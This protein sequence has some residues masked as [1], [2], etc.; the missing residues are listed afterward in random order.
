M[1]S[2]Q[3]TLAFPSPEL[4][5]AVNDLWSMI[6]QAAESLNAQIE[7]NK[8][9]KF[10]LDEVTSNS[11]EESE[12]V[13]RLRE[14]ASNL[15][16]E[17]SLREDDV[18]RLKQQIESFGSLQ[19][20][21]NE[22]NHGYSKAQEEIVVLNEQLDLMQVLQKNTD[23][24]ELALKKSVDE[25]LH[26]NNQLIEASEETL[27]LHNE[28]SE[29]KNQIHQISIDGDSNSL[30]Q[31][32]L[33]TE[34]HRVKE[35]NSEL[36]K[37]RFDY[38]VLKSEAQIENGKITKDHEEL[39]FF[40]TSL[41]AKNLV[42]DSALADE[43]SNNE[44]LKSEISKLIDMNSELTNLLEDSKG[45]LALNENLPIQLSDVEQELTETKNNLLI[46]NK[47]LNDLRRKEIEFNNKIEYLEKEIESKEKAFLGDKS[48]N[49]QV[50]SRFSSLESLLQQKDMLIE[51]ANV[52][53]QNL[54]SQVQNNNLSEVENLEA[55]IKEKDSKLIELKQFEGAF[56]KLRQE[57]AD[58]KAHG[59]DREKQLKLSSE[60]RIELES[61][62]FNL[63]TESNKLKRDQEATNFTMQSLE[64]QIKLLQ[65]RLKEAESKSI[66]AKQAF[67]LDDAIKESLIN[68]IEEQLR[69]INQLIN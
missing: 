64:S 29:L 3:N 62:V 2:P 46:S 49:Q 44:S 27:K 21:F 48:A 51:E 38:D 13:E 12:Q 8:N 47:Q 43:R 52:T 6:H 16:T 65:Q 26:K 15:Y 4:Q 67:T 42:L 28:I 33:L 7:Q 1:E 55:E 58:L 59:D 56:H 53:I 5:N 24:L 36:N 34:E 20:N 18:S 17:I 19:D 41:N 31:S 10:K 63:R 30:L 57:I 54:K 37:L 66:N 14:E 40:V 25:I 68:K 69:K 9:L 50:L 35:L 11:G 61:R 60:E 45:K 23:E 22:L 39:K 32:Q